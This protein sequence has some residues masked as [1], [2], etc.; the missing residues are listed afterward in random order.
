MLLGPRPHG[1]AFRHPLDEDQARQREARGLDDQVLLGDTMGELLAF[2]GAVDLV[3]VG[4]SLV[5]VGGH[6][7]IEPAAWGKPVL[8]GPELFNFAAAAALLETGG[9]LWICA[10]GAALADAVCEL[11]AQPERRGGPGDGRCRRRRV[12]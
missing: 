2:C 4:G 11:L 7:L 8:S 12:S 10:D 6:N 5:P 3:F 1:R 9:G